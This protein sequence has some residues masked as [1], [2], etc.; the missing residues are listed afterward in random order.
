[1]QGRKHIVLAAR[2]QAALDMLA[3]HLDDETSYEVKLHP[4]VNGHTD[5]LH[6]VTAMPDILVLRVTPNSL[7]ELSAL[8]ARPATDRPPLLV[9][10]AS[11]DPQAMRLAMQSGARDFL[12]E[13]VQKHDFVTALQRVATE[14]TGKSVSEH[15]TQ[16]VAFINAK[17]GSGASFMATNVAH[18][19][20]A[21]Q[22][23]DTVLVDLDLQFGSLPQYLDLQPKRGLV[24][25]LE[26]VDELDSVAVDAYLTRHSSGLRLL[27]RAPAGRA[28]HIESSAERFAMLLEMLKAKAQR[29]VFDVPRHLDSI[30]AMTLERADRVVVV[31]QQTLPSVRD[32]TRLMEIA[33]DEIGIPQHRLSVLVNRYRKGAPVEL[34]DIRRPLRDEDPFVVPNHFGPVSESIDAGVPIYEHARSSPVTRA[35]L[36]IARE[37]DGGP[38]KATSRSFINRTISSFLRT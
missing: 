16:S 22:R 32:A 24:E 27:S 33:R 30:G 9:I 31:V 1:M 10:G 8:A 6:G 13:P 5:P 14:S 29:I 11:E 37:L 23:I 18:V 35:I 7:D 36:D 17:G 3:R 38:S 26:V 20:T 2:S 12:S 21:V 34:N 28:P 25:A 19:S 15:R 4:I